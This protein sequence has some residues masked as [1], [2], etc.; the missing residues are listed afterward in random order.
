[1]I[2]V[3]D[4]SVKI[5]QLKPALFHAANVYWQLRLEYGVKLPV[6]ITSG[7]DGRHSYGSKHWSNDAIDLRSK[8]IEDVT[9]KRVI[10]QSLKEYLGLDFD[11]ILEYEGEANEHIHV[12]C[13]PKRR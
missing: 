4:D 6:T 11:V 5:S 7:N 12:E 1:M 8:D 10:V 13:H 2:R 9:T 3:K